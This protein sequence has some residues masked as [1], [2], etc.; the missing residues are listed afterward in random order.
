MLEEK[1]Y[2]YF[3]FR[4]QMK[5]SRRW[6]RDSYHILTNLYIPPNKKIHKIYEQTS[7]A[8]NIKVHEVPPVQW[9][10]CD[11]TRYNLHLKINPLYSNNNSEE[12]DMMFC[13]AFVLGLS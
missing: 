4:L 12:W 8:A 2:D 13:L 10:V 11:W 9:V 1:I 6:I 5:S 7:F 3:I